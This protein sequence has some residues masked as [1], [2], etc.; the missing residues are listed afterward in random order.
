[1]CGA[2]VGGMIVLKWNG[3]GWG[4]WVRPPCGIG[5]GMGGVGRA[6]GRVCARPDAPATAGARL[7]SRPLCNHCVLRD[8]GSSCPRTLRSTWGPST[9]RC[10]RPCPAP[11]AP[12]CGPSVGARRCRRRRQGSG[13]WPTPRTRAGSLPP[14]WLCPRR[15][16]ST[17]PVRSLRNSNC[18]AVHFRNHVGPSL[19]TILPVLLQLTKVE[20]QNSPFHS[21]TTLQPWGLHHTPRRGGGGGGELH[22]RALLCHKLGTHTP[23]THWSQ[24]ARWDDSWRRRPPLRVTG[25]GWAGQAHCA[26]RQQAHNAAV[27]AVVVVVV[28]SGGIRHPGATLP[29]PAL[30]LQEEHDA[31]REGLG[32]RRVRFL[33]LK[34]LKEEGGGGGGGREGACHQARSTNRQPPPA[35]QDAFPLP[36]LTFKQCRN[37]PTISGSSTSIA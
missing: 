3:A 7:P 23:C 4:G 24:K 27:R 16:L 37:S 30:R 12:S 9:P 28:A 17:G 22:K 18:I 19:S 20:L 35:V 36:A 5:L 29:A 32:K 34:D 31:L 1:M 26:V 33:H 11:R 2:G 15:R 25:R 21:L 6:S 14:S 10:A 13:R 8:V